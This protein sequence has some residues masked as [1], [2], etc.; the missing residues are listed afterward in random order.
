MELNL[1][2]LKL[3]IAAAESNSL[4]E[5]A[6]KTGYD[7]SNVSS[8][9]SKFEQQLGIKLFTRNPLRLTDIGRDV[10]KTVIRGY[11]DIEFAEVIAKSKN[12]IEYGKISVGCPVNITKIFFLDRISKAVK[13]HPNLQI[14]IDNE[15]NYKKILKK[16]ENNL[17]QFALLDFI[18]TDED[19]KKFEINRIFKDGSITKNGATIQNIY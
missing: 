14:T 11:R 19:I 9:I 15:T 4:T 7:N 16:I 2:Y 13:E 1:N 10:Y 17:I 12:D 6:E 8:T 3:F 5:V 18:P